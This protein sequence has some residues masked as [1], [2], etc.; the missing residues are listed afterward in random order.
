MEA[1]L[2]VIVRTLLFRLSLSPFSYFYFY[3]N[4]SEGRVR[5]IFKVSK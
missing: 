3:L 5:K 4:R 1:K 2:R